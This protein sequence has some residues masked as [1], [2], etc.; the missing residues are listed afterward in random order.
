MRYL[1]IVS[2]IWA[3]S[4][5][6]IKT[7]LT[8]LDPFVV[9]GVRLF[10]ALLVF[11]PFLRLRTVDRLLSIQFL[12][13][14]AVQFGVMYGA[15]IYTFQYMEAHKIALFTVTT[16][17]MVTL[18]DDLLEKQFRVSFFLCAAVSVFG[19]VVIYYNTIDLSSTLIGIFLLQVSNLCFAAGQ[20]LYRRLLLSSPHLRSQDHF[21][22]LYL[23]GVVAT[24]GLMAFGSDL[25]SVSFSGSQI[26]VILLLGV[27]ASGL[28]FF[29]W[30]Y[31]ATL[32]NAGNL[33]V[34]N[35]L[36]IPLAV[37]VSLLFFEDV[38]RQQL[39]RLVTG[40]G[41]IV[42][43]VYLNDFLSSRRKTEPV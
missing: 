12:A 2:V 10:V 40:G 19:A 11:L 41:I 30:N 39:L 15:Y 34:M 9:S 32:T 37:A 33:A 42:G 20:V 14:G 28:G 43:A 25:S 24:L 3:F 31:G 8:G 17:L 1:I 35:N 7:Y 13:I 38:T 4:F 29:L 5:G 36:K 21:A 23:G 16:P 18:L 26:A 27:V 6:L 22:W